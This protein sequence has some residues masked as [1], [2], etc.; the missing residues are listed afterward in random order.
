MRGVVIIIF[1]L[2]APF[3][4]AQE[5]IIDDIKV[6]LH[7]LFL[8]SSQENRVTGFV[9]HELTPSNLEQAEQVPYDPPEYEFTQ[10]PAEV[11]KKEHELISPR[12]QLISKLQTTIDQMSLEATKEEPVITYV[13]HVDGHLVPQS[14]ISFFVEPAV[15]DVQYTLRKDDVSA[16]LAVAHYRLPSEGDYTITATFKAQDKTITL[17][18]SFTVGIPLSETVRLDLSSEHGTHMIRGPAQVTLVSAQMYSLDM[19][20]YFLAGKKVRVPLG[21]VQGV[22]FLPEGLFEVEI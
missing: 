9:V 21:S 6:F 13:L 16:T 17:N 15:Q 2:C 8:R 5:S 18:K 20:M 7:E 22:V 4:F 14:Q 1:L 10:E 3:A 12:D 19:G 11:V